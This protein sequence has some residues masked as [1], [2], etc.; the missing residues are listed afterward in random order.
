MPGKRPASFT[1]FAV[2]C[3]VFASLGLLCNI[4]GLASAKALESLQS[5][6]DRAK[7]KAME[8]EM[9][10]RIPGYQTQQWAN[11]VVAVVMELL[12]LATGIGLLKMLP[13]SRLACITYGVLTILI[14][15]ALMI[16][17]IAFISPVLEDV[18][19][20]QLR[21]QNPQAQVSV[22]GW[23]LNSGVIFISLV[24]MAFA[25]TL[26]IFAL[27]PK[28]AQ[29]LAGAGNLDTDAA[30]GRQEPQD[31]YDED[32]QRQRHEPPPEL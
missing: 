19:N 26:L 1:V 2:L 32:Y 24:A 25:T 6:A 5:E 7:A 12:L 15:L 11:L 3:I 22:P 4:G 17:T 14:Q 18:I 8:K 20:R 10:E 30:L 27:R 29:Q 21:E 28:M 23:L 9:L 31:F 16:Y 13:W